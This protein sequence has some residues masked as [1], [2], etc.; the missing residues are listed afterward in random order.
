MSSTHS[1]WEQL[2]GEDCPRSESIRVRNTVDRGLLG[3]W[4]LLGHAAGVTDRWV[5][6]VLGSATIE[7]SSARNCSGPRQAGLVTSF[8]ET[9]FVRFDRHSA[10][11]DYFETALS[12]AA[13]PA[14]IASGNL[15]RTWTSAARSGSVE[16]RFP[17]RPSPGGPPTGS[18]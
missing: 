9:S 13:I 7:D 3:V 6:I 1:E 5:I 18:A 12:I 4:S 8:A 17:P 10:E 16:E 14:L 15:G 2:L 11:C